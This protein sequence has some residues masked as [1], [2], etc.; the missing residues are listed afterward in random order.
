M[1]ILHSQ[2]QG[3]HSGLHISLVQEEEEDE[4][5]QDSLVP[6]ATTDAWEEAPALAA[7]TA[8]PLHLNWF[9]YLSFSCTLSHLSSH[10]RG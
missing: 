3:D 5:G 8:S 6:L 9:P 10:G 2:A 4:D 1:S 7:T